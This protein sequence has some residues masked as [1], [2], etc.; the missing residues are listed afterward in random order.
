VRKQNIVETGFIIVIARFKRL[1]YI[2]KLIIIYIIFMN[3]IRKF[4]CASLL[5]RLTC[6]ELGNRINED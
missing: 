2:A 1:N 3:Y 4:K 5:R 6:P